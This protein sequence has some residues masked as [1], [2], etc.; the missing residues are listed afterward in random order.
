MQSLTQLLHKLQYNQQQAQQLQ[1]QTVYVGQ[2]PHIY[3]VVKLQ[4]VGDILGTPA[5]IS[6]VSVKIAAVLTTELVFSAQMHYTHGCTQNNTICFQ[7]NQKTQ[8]KRLP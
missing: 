5:A 4:E 1:S 3:K 2:F 6:P 7:M 8:Q